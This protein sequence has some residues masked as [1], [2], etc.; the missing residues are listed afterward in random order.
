M[1]GSGANMLGYYMFAGGRNPDGGAI[2][3]QESQRSGYPT[4]VP[5]KSYDFQAP[6]SNNGKKQES[7]RRMKLVHYFLNDFGEQLAPM[8]VHRPSTTPSNAEDLSVSRVSARTRGDNGF[9]FLNNYT[10]NGSMPASRFSGATS[11]A[12]RQGGRARRAHHPAIR[13]LWNLARQ[14]G[15]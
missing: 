3:L 15:T 9:V 11:L 12:Q 14:P 8:R 7:L 4:D 13:S 6:I 10:R 1:L 2:T 5:A